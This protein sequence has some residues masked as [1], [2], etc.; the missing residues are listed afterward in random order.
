VGSSALAVRLSAPEHFTPVHGVCHPP[1][2]IYPVMTGKVGV[3]LRSHAPRRRQQL[4]APQELS[5]HACCRFSSCGEAPRSGLHC[6][7]GR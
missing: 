6:D 2:S 3:V 5:A 1:S 7:A 4:L